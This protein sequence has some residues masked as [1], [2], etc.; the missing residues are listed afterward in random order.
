MAMAQVVLYVGL[1]LAAVIVT[2]ALLLITKIVIAVALGCALV[3]GAIVVLIGRIEI[4]FW[5]P[6]AP[7]AF[8]ANAIFAFL[9]SLSFIAIGRWLRWPFFITKRRNTQ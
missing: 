5:D 9:V 1:A 3:I 6:L 4:G 8:V 7:V 2:A